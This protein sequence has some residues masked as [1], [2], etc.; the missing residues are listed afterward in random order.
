MKKVP[1]VAYDENGENRRVVGEGEAK[2]EDGKLV[3][4]AIV[5][6]DPTILG[7]SDSDGVHFSVIEDESEA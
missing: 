4:G 7:F 2:I 3:V 1:F 6:D 5:F